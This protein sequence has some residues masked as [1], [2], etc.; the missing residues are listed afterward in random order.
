MVTFSSLG[1][2]GRFGNQL[3]QVASIIGIAKANG[4]EYAFPKWVNHDARNRFGSVEDINV[5]KWFPKWE[6]IQTFSNALPEYSIPWGWNGLNHP[7]GHSYIGHMQSEKYFAHCADYIRE[8]FVLDKEKP[9]NHCT[10][11]H[12]RCG[13]YGGDYHPIMSKEYYAEAMMYNDGPYIIFSDDFEKAMDIVG[14]F[15][16]LQDYFYHGNTKDSFALMKSCKNHII[17]NST[18]S[19]WAAW[20]ANG[21]VVA[22]KKWFGPLASHLETKDIYPDNWI[23]I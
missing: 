2:Y 1:N 23:I 6:E 3:F 18:F 11:V 10:A 4:Y 14:D 15:L 17:A 12:I 9:K 5:G 16:G 20:L 7:D 22:P 8:L 19:W 21:N 13:D